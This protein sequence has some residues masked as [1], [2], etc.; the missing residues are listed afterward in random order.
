MKTCVDLGKTVVNT[1]GGWWI[2]SAE[3]RTSLQ[4]VPSKKNKL[5]Q[6]Y[7]VLGVPMEKRPTRRSKRKQADALEIMSGYF[8]QH[9]AALPSGIRKHREMIIAL[10]MEGHSAEEAFAMVQMNAG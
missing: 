5:T 8:Q 9:K 1:W 2:G 6:S 4:Q 3:G 10:L 7:S